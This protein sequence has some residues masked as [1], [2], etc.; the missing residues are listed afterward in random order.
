MTTAMAAMTKI[1]TKAGG[2]PNH[3]IG[4]GGVGV[5]VGV[6]AEVTSRSAFS[7]HAEA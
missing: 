1:M 2:M 6:G 4:G 5:G 3:F 7:L